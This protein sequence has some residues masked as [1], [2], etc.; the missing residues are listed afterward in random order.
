MK[1]YEEV[2]SYELPEHLWSGGKDAYDRLI[3]MG[4][5]S[6]SIYD[7]VVELL[8]GGDEDEA[9]DITS[10]NN[11]LWFDFDSIREYLG[12]VDWDEDFPD[13]DLESGINILIDKFHDPEIDDDERERN[14]ELLNAAND[15]KHELS[16]CREEKEISD[17]LKDLIEKVNE[18]DED[19]LFD[20]DDLE[21]FIE[22]VG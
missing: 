21:E 6:D 22:K 16:K 9:V 8:C 5:T 13:V 2:N 1:I 7:A 17:K 15:L 4:A 12:L 19:L 11:A 18:L 10:V 3:E 14:T 20:F